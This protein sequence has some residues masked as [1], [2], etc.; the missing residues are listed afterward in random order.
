MFLSFC[1]FPWNRGKNLQGFWS[2]YCW[3]WK[4]F[5]FQLNAM[6]NTLVE[7]LYKKTRA[8]LPLLSYLDNLRPS[9]FDF[10][11]DNTLAISAHIYSLVL[12]WKTFGFQQQSLSTCPPYNS[13]VYCIFFPN[14][15]TW[16]YLIQR[17][18]CAIRRHSHKK[19]M[20]TLFYDGNS[21]YSANVYG[22]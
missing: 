14:S 7:A 3:T 16:P 22:G 21:F 15:I 19:Y 6:V 5:K 13:L 10:K 17:K 8:H 4:C 1:Y 12:L 2:H 20:V 9:D 11:I 18:P